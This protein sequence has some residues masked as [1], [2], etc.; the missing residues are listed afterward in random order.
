MRIT[1]IMTRDIH[2]VAP[3][4]D[5]ED[6]WE[7]MKTEGVRHLV[8]KEGATVVGI[9][10][11]VDAGGRHGALVRSTHTVGELMERKV[12][13]ITPHDTVRDAANL[14][15]AN[16]ATC[17]LVVDDGKPRGLVTVDDLL[18]VIGR[19]IDRPGREDR[20]ALSHRVPHR[21]TAGTG[22]W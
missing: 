4:M 15:R 3:T 9:L 8:V 19:G 14:L 2:T 6:A 16:S 21:K 22:R 1:E 13:T 10:S 20:P 17:L 12:R 11:D 5:A 7:L 18:L